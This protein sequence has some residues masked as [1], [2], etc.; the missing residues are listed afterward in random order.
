M[1]TEKR[2]ADREKMAAAVIALATECDA[3]AAIDPDWPGER[4]IMLEIR[5]AR[6]L[7]LNIDF[8]GDSPQPDVHVLS[9][10]MST[11]VDTCF[12]DAFGDLNRFHYRKA[13]GVAHGFDELLRSIHTGLTLAASGEAFSAER[14]AAAIAKAG[15]T[16]AQRNSRYDAWRTAGQQV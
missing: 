6:G 3:T 5:A 9:W 8:D 4:A 2:K 15:E 1:L 12:A 10:H 7:C 13:T 11:D 16:A 14:E